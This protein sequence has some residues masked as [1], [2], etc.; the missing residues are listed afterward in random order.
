MTG[1]GVDGSPN[2]TFGSRVYGRPNGW[3]ST[4]LRAI[5]I[6]VGNG[7]GVSI[8]PDWDRPWARDLGIAALALPDAEGPREVGMLW[9]RA[10]PVRSLVAAV[11]EACAIRRH[12]G[13]GSRYRD[14]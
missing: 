5:A 7:L 3:N 14:S 8:V 11:L 1:R 10:S 2:A 12:R 6:M 13:S 9:P 4:S